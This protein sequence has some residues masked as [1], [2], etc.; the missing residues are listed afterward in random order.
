MYEYSYIIL[1]ACISQVSSLSGIE[2]LAALEALNVANTAVPTDSMLC[3]RGLSQLKVL[4]IANTANINGDLALEYLQGNH[5]ADNG[6]Y[7]MKWYK[8]E[9]VV[10]FLCLLY[11]TYTDYFT[12][13]SDVNNANV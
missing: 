8:L 7:D 10:Q 4:N 11:L 9:W 5:Q 13:N 12:V 2:G 6:V 3:I 1:S